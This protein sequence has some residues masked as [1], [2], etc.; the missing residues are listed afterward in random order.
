MD[1]LTHNLDSCGN[2]ADFQAGV[3][4]FNA[5]HFW[6]AHEEWE[7]LWL[8]SHGTQ[9]RF[10]QGLIQVAAALVH[11]QRGNPRGLRLNWA[12]ARPKLLGLPSPAGGIE[13]AA[14][15][16]WMDGMADAAVSEA[17]TL[18]AAGAEGGSP[19]N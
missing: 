5:G 10:V 2:D 9:R 8:R 7:A 17:P 11:W 6:H 16:A 12:K 4:L 13:L 3:R 14:L 19:P 15:I 18:P 1:D